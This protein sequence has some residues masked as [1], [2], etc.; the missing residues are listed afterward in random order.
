[1]IRSRWVLLAL[2]ALSVFLMSGCSRDSSSAKAG[3][4][5][6]S[7]SAK[8]GGGASFVP[9][10][11]YLIKPQGD[12]DSWIMC[13]V[14]NTSGAALLDVKADLKYV[15]GSGQPQDANVSVMPPVLAPGMTGFIQGSSTGKPTS[16]TI[17]P[18]YTP[19]TGAY[20]G[21]WTISDGG[22]RGGATSGPLKVTIKNN[23]TKTMTGIRL[24][25]VLL[26][27]QGKAGAVSDT[28]A[29]Q[30]RLAPGESGQAEFTAY[31]PEPFEYGS[32]EFSV[33]CSTE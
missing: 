15:D 27:K 4:A 19:D 28:Y 16:V 1:M 21:D 11:S 17:V 10:T 30:E 32:H 12:T 18:S 22:W 23:G 3:G 9:E 29:V 24:F 14:K 2:V 33:E 8:G 13:S 6:E 31:A 25:I 7:A 26:D 5:A 20:Y